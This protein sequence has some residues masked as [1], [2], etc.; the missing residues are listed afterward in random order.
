MYKN[1]N[2]TSNLYNFSKLEDLFKTFF[3]T[4]SQVT[5][6]NLDNDI[7]FGIINSTMCTN[8]IV[9]LDFDLTLKE[10]IEVPI[11]FMNSKKTIQF[12]YIVKG[13]CDYIS[14]NGDTVNFKQ[15]QSAIAI[16]K[17]HTHA[18]LRFKKNTPITISIIALNEEVYNK[19]LDKESCSFS[20]RALAF[21]TN[22]N[23]YTPF[24]LGGY[25]YAISERVEHYFRQIKNEQH[26][27]SLSIEA[28]IYSMLSN[29][30]QLALNYDPLT[31]ESTLSFG[32]LKKINDLSVAIRKSPEIQY[33]LSTLSSEIGLSPA[34]LQ[35]GFKLLFGRTVSDYIRHVR[36][37]RAEYL[38][39]TTDL[40]VSEIV[41]S[42]GF[43]SRSY[44][45]KIFK[46]EFNQSPKD[47]KK[48][49]A[50]RALMTIA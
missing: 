22:L 43:T 44:F 42:I 36:L 15:Y 19:I 5:N 24:H 39:C 33:S 28:D 16:S 29:H 40:N 26:R 11:H 8:G 27:W 14:N 3:K 25:D 4:N 47:Y 13:D 30:F 2:I 21:I 7:G 6:L 37:K 38:M 1:S 34:K 31:S 46:K 20:L 45:C 32:E 10:T 48:N 35:E 41:Y 12:L 9:T 17:K 50:G 18:K 49:L 23:D